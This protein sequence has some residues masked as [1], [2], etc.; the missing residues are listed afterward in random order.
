MKKSTLIVLITLVIV[1][2]LG[3]IFGIIYG[4]MVTAPKRRNKTVPLQIWNPTG[5]YEAKATTNS[6]LV[7][8]AV[9]AGRSNQEL[10]G[11]TIMSPNFGYLIDVSGGLQFTPDRARADTWSYLTNYPTTNPAAFILT[12]D[13]THRSLM[14]I[15]EQTV[16]LDVFNPT[17]VNFMWILKDGFLIP[18]AYLNPAQTFEG[19]VLLKAG[20]TLVLDGARV[21]PY[22]SS[23]SP[24][25]FN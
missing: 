1:V 15:S 13:R 10:H 18:G 8:G 16:A 24:L 2:V 6:V 3:T 17:N 5:P 19:E 9:A 4:I 14:T 20:D 23:A 12:N 25:S 21:L 11:V 22:S 7:V